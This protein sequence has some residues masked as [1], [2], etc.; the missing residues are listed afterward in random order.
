MTRPL[1]LLLGSVVFLTALT[2][3]QAQ[4][5]AQVMTKVKAHA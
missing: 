3:A 4:A 1:S 2:A 5:Q